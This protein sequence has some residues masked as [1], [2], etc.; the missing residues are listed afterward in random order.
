MIKKSC[1]QIILNL[2]IVFF[3]VVL[4]QRKWVE[5]RKVTVKKNDKERG[6][7]TVIIATGF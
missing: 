1:L 3:I 7:K 6:R 5:T 2:M 4:V